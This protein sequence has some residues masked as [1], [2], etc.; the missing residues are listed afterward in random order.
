MR[1]RLQALSTS[2]VDLDVRVHV[3]DGGLATVLEE[4]IAALLGKPAAV[5]FPT[6]TM[7]QQVSLRCWSERTR[8]ST[9]ALHPLSH[10]EVHER[11]AFTALTGLRGVWP[12]REPRQPIAVEVREL[13]EPF[14]TLLLELPLRDAGYLLPTWDELVALVAAAR[15]RGARVHFDGARLWESAPHLGQDLPTIAGLADSVYVSLY[16]TLGGLAG[17]ALAGPTDFVAEARAWR[18]RYGGNVAQHWPAALAA[19]AGIDAELPRLDS[20][21]AHA[22]VVSS[23]LAELPGARV[24]PQPPHTHQFQMWLPHAA[25]S[26]NE[27]AFALA[28][29]EKIWFAGIWVDRPP[30]GLSVTEVTVAAPALELSPDDVAAAGRAFLARVTT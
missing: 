28:E 22:K 11:K 15:D 17:S 3:Y 7:A 25:E 19:L 26:L 5:F 8:N 16:K 30:T 24:H 27:A 4:R 20:Y 14:G 29:A 23:A 6:G 1:E 12:T 10:L 9:V 13:D 18:H 21:V 2:D